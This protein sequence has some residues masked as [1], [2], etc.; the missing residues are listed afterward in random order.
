MA[1][2]NPDQHPNGNDDEPRGRA[3]KKWR[4]KGGEFVV[5]SYVTDDY[6]GF[7]GTSEGGEPVAPIT[8]KERRR[9]H[10]LARESMK[11]IIDRSGTGKL[12]DV[13]SVLDEIAT[14]EGREAYFDMLL[15]IDDSDGRLANL[16]VDDC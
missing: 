15:E 7:G 16:P 4:P 12:E 2:P 8:D 5:L 3:G 13:S 1:L 9:N 6:D 11:W 14:P 10:L